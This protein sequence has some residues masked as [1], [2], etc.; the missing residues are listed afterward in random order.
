MLL[1]FTAPELTESGSSTVQT[2]NK[3]SKTKGSATKTGKATK[4]AT[5]TAKTTK[6][7]KKTTKAAEKA[8]KEQNGQTKQGTLEERVLAVIDNL[9]DNMEEIKQ[10]DLQVVDRLEVLVAH[11]AAL[12]QRHPIEEEKRKHEV[13]SN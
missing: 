4:G 5:N 8:P 10:D 12:E 3:S 2:V 9:G 11:H 6:T 13:H 7:T 1:T